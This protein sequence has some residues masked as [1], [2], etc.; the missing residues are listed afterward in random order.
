MSTAN[1]NL[2]AFA[3]NNLP[4]PA[5]LEGKHFA[6]I[7]AEWNHEITFA[8]AEGARRAFADHG[9]CT[10][11]VEFYDVPGTFELT[12]SAAKLMK[13]GRFDAII[14]I[15]CVIRGETPHFDY[16][17]EGV[18]NGISTL[19]SQGTCPVI[20]SVLTTENLQQAQ[21]RAGGSLGN[22]GYEGAICALKMF[23]TFGGLK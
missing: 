20:F 2:E 10:E 7:Y 1:F 17:C 13:T 3:Q 22:K 21:E 8:L 6:V 18:A 14:V 12:F 11:N 19:N 9:V 16:I 15:G 23:K 4:S 5:E